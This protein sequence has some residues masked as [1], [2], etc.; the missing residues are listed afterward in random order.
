MIISILLRNFKTYRGINFIPLTN[1]EKFCGILGNNGIGKT[2]ILEALDCYF[3]SR[4]W[5]LHVSIRRSGLTT[6][7]AS[8]TPIFLIK[9][10][11]IHT[12]HR[13]LCEKISTVIWN[14]TDAD[15]A[16]ANKPYL[17]DFVDQR[18]KI[19]LNYSED[20]YYLL[21]IG[22][23]YPNANSFGVF[24]CKKLGESV[25]DGFTNNRMNA[26]ELKLLDDLK[27]HL[28]EIYEY[29]YIP[30][31]ISTVE[32]TQ[33]ER[34]EIQAL[35]G[36][37][38]HQILE[39]RVTQTQIREINRN[40]NDFISTLS[41]E[42]VDYS[43]RT[44]TERQQ[45]LKKQDIYN[46]IIQ[47]YFNPRRLHKKEGEQWLDI[48]N[49]SSGE[50]QKAIIDVAHNLIKNHHSNSEN[51]ILAVDEPES[52]LHMSACFEHFIKMFEISNA[53]NQFFF[54]TH[55]YGF[56][57]IIDNGSVISITKGTAKHDFDYLSLANYREL[58]KQQIRES[59]GSLPHD[60]RLKSMNDFIQSIISSVLDEEPFNWIL[61]EGSSEKIYFE[62]YFEDLK[63]SH[64]LRIIP[65]GGAGEIK[66]IYQN[67]SVAIEEFK[68]E[69]K[70][71]IYF[72]IDTDSELLSFE[73]S[74]TNKIAVKRMVNSENDTKLV[75]INSN[76]KSPVTEVED[77]LNG[78]AFYNTL[79]KFKQDYAEEL[80][81]IEAG[82]TI[83]Q[84]PSYYALDLRVTER[85]KLSVFF[86]T[87]NNKF[88]FANSYIDEI[89][90]NTYDTPN[91][92]TE[93]RT[94]ITSE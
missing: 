10:E 71:K 41:T 29:I 72:L 18:E 93:I 89:K 25:I 84:I 77:V 33:L 90:E 35:M 60:I 58:V 32:L 31:D 73:T 81:F 38:L 44:P 61:C 46:L 24:N 28:K 70:G 6:I 64:K 69:I 27:Y 56:L 11:K 86:D 21:P 20:E 54:T 57:P 88:K 19:I 92:I 62:G 75:N 16:A 85:D 79:L 52:S 40:L 50:K 3:N 55:W 49:L 94:F 14:I 87:D 43:F 51:L 67:L 59:R 2:S 9:K 83:D 74:N 13:D 8:I 15:V 5:N 48:E 80:D 17:K 26:E 91:W 65:V 1:E 22:N 36:E 66:R 39:S 82:E 68:R 4:D 7:A 42:L 34:K 63:L 30:K 12:D 45:N 23:E 47:A 76:P 37:S 78:L 53:C